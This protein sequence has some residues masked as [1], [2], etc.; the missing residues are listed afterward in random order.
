MSKKRGLSMIIHSSIAS[1]L[2][3]GF[4][5]LI[6]VA[7]L[8]IFLIGMNFVSFT[9]QN[10]R[11]QSV[12]VVE[13]NASKGLIFHSSGFL[14]RHQIGSFWGNF[15]SKE[16]SLDVVIKTDGVQKNFTC[17]IN[18]HGSNSCA[19]EIYDHTLKCECFQ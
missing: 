8:L 19:V 9:A 1:R 3:G 6:A 13:V 7:V 14:A 2:L 16:I 12:N 15:P 17:K 5:L 4:F 11:R 18:L 10:F